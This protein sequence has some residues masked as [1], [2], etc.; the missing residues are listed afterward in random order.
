MAE[1]KEAISELQTEKER[2]ETETLQKVLDKSP[3]RKQSF[4]GISLEPVNRLYAQAD[5]EMIDRKKKLLF[6]A[7]SHTR[8]AF[9]RPVTADGFGQCASSPVFRRLRKQMRVLNI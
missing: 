9:I 5:L 4:E 3:E 8:A 1:V 2:W 6:P 7:S